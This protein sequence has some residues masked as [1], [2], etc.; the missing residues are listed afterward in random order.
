MTFVI[1]VDKEEVLSETRP[2][3]RSGVLSETDSVSACYTSG[4]SGHRPRL[5]R[6]VMYLVM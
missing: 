6:V 3:V 2:L 1:F 4:K 5:K